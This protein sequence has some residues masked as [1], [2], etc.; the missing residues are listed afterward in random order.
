MELDAAELEGRAGLS[1]RVMS[2]TLV[3][4]NFGA[5][6]RLK[7]RAVFLLLCLCMPQN[8]LFSEQKGVAPPSCPPP[9]TC[10]PNRMDSAATT[11]M[12][13]DPICMATFLLYLLLFSLFLLCLFDI[14]LKVTFYS[15]H[16]GVCWFIS[17]QRIKTY[18]P[19][20]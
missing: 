11:Q 15:C 5:M 9:A 18:R 7:K 3:G 19:I 20:K 4:C 10:A 13:M 8:L 2:A 1:M 6:K 14:L 17:S 16:F 12:M